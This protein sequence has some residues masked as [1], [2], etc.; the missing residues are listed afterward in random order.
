MVKKDKALNKAMKKTIKR[1][2]KKLIKLMYTEK[3][4]FYCR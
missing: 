4:G 3:R 1:N 2:T